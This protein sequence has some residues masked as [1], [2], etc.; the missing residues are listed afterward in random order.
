MNIFNTDSAQSKALNKNGAFFAFS[1]KQF[2]EAKKENTKYISLGG[3]LIAPESN[4]E[5]LI[6]ELDSICTQKI[7]FELNNN[8][9]KDIIW[10]ELANHECQISCDYE[11]VISLL[12]PYGITEDMIKA[13]FSDYY[14][15]CVDNDYF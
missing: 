8:S 14:Q 3:G 11:S 10:Y 5:S 12:K 7:E 2:D 4:A 15:H 1:N 13:E 9:I 6:K